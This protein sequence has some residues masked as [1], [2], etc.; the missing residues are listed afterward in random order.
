LYLLSSSD[1]ELLATEDLTQSPSLLIP[2]YDSDINVVFLYA[3]VSHL[4]R[5]EIQNGFF[6]I[7]YFD[8]G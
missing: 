8:I 2:F 3:K 7:S 1:L 4:Q 5:D 6:S